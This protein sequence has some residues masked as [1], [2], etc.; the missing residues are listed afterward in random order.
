MHLAADYFMNS[1]EGCTFTDADSCDAAATCTW[2]KSAAVKSKCYDVA[3]A[4]SLPSSIFACDKLAE[5][6]EQIEEPVHHQH[7]HERKS[8]DE[9]SESDSEEEDEMDKGFYN[10]KGQGHHGKNHHGKHGKGKGC[11][12]VG[13]LILMIAVFAH[14]FNMRTFI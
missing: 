5:E 1:A 6:V 10:V 11:R 12:F 3:Q 14:F 8:D 13:P 7:H 2:C 9:E 4:K